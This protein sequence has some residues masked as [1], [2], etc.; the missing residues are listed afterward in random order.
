MPCAQLFGRLD[1]LLDRTRQPVELPHHQRVVLAR[2]FQRRRQ[3]G[4]IRD[5]TR[6]LL[7]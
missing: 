1:Q 3:S 7:G 2:E 4:A 5:R 6:H